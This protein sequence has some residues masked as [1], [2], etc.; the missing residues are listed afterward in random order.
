MAIE[1]QAKKADLATL[2]KVFNDAIDD[3]YTS[4][5]T[6]DILD[7]LE[8]ISKYRIVDQGGFPE[9][10]MR[11]TANIGAKGSSVIPLDLESNVVWLHH[12]LFDD[13][14]YEVTDSVREYSR[15]IEEETSPYINR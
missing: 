3:I 12:F 13:Q 15:K 14:E 4:L 8:N 10:S 5:D 2:T 9:E 11:T 6:Q 7:L 1:E